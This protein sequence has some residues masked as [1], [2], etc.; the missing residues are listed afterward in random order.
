MSGKR[1]T[2]AAGL[3]PYALM[4]RFYDADYKAAGSVDDI[5]FYSSI[6]KELGEPVLEMGC[7]SGR[8]LLPIARFGIAIHGI[9]A[10]PAM[11]RVLRGKLRLEPPRV[12][13]RTR[14]SQGDIRSTHIGGRYGLVTAPFRVAQHLLRPGDRRAW[15]RNV[16]RHLEPA[17]RLCFD[18]VNPGPDLLSHPCEEAG[19][20]VRPLSTGRLVV[21]SV[22]TRPR[23]D[24][25]MIEVRYKWQVKDARGTPVGEWRTR[26]VFHLYSRPELEALLESQGFEIVSY[27]GSFKREPFGPHSTDHVILSRLRPRCSPPG[28]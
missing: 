14:V 22:S 27:W 2:Q 19:V 8:N 15:L 25:G 16:A 23:T 24:S 20:I 17:G 1:D 21:R 28:H 13:R 4:A 18:V 11:L 12:R 7:G 3:D 6:A 9:D 5:A 10:S 26:L